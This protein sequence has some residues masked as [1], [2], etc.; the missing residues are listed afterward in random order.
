LWRKRYAHGAGVLGQRLPVDGQLYT[1][2]GVAP[3]DMLDP[4]FGSLVRSDI[5]T[6]MPRTNADTAF[7]IFPVVRLKPGV[8]WQAA[9]TDL[10]RIEHNLHGLNAPMLGSS[11][12]TSPL[13]ATI[14][15][16]AQGF[17]WMVY[18]AVT[19]ILLIA[20]ANVAN[21]LLLRAST[22]QGEFAVRSAIGASTRR[23]ASQ[24]L[25]EALLLAAAGA[26]MGL[27]LAWAALPWAKGI[28]PGNL[29][30][31]QNAHID[32]TVLAYVC[33][34]LVAV[35]L[36]TGLLPA[37]RPKAKRGHD[38]ASAM[39][40][41]LVVV[42]VAI[43]FAMTTGFGLM[44]QSFQSLTNVELGFSPHGVYAATFAFRRS[45]FFSLGQSSP[46][47]EVASILRQLRAIPGVEDASV[48]TSMPFQNGFNMSYLLP[49][50]WNGPTHP[51]PAT[52]MSAVQVGQRY[53]QV[54]R[55]PLASGRAFGR[56]DFVRANKN[57]IV[58]RA[59]VQAYFPHEDAVG[60]IVRVSD[61]PLVADRI[62]GVVANVRNS[63]RA[64][65]QPQMYSPFDGGFGPFYGFVIRTSR[66]VPG[67]SK[68]IAQ[69]LRHKM[70]GVG[71]ITVTPLADLIAK[72]ASSTR[73]TLDL[74]GAFAAVALLLGLCGVYSVVAYGTQRRFHEIG[75]RMAVGARPASIVRLVLG[76]TIVQGAAGVAAGVVLCAFTTRLLDAQLYGT[77]PLDPRTLVAVAALL[78]LCMVSAAAIPAGRAALAKPTT[79]LRYE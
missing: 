1:I 53:F 45:M 58:N 39:R 3:A 11:L 54:M 33:G 23:I 51:L 22:R 44:L 79:T 74:L 21:L 7:P 13:D 63:L 35:T 48:A 14:F 64:L 2:I 29:P 67:I 76:S 73:T 10:A 6:I 69:I 46:H 71:T 78:V 27:F 37:Y 36:L 4:I 5:W 24:V 15:A 50:G 12:A 55:I 34:L 30:R 72:D 66:D 56:D 49:K 61:K 57:I 20:C 26:G 77:S 18:A 42:Q 43:A 17:L 68:Q 31:V 40:A 8:T 47:P 70:R 32:G 28:V 9:Q 19:G 59:F 16:G 62:V 52:P 38:A 75:I 60:K 41:S 65:P 25:T